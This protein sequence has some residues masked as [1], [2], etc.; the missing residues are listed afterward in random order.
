M[1]ALIIISH[2]IM[3]MIIKK[4]VMNSNIRCEILKNDNQKT[5]I[6]P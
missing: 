5:Q 4:I 2:K 3:I 1:N 6:K